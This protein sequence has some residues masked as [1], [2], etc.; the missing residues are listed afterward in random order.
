MGS[1]TL[2]PGSLLLLYLDFHCRRQ[3][4]GDSTTCPPSPVIS[5]P[6]WQLWVEA[7]SMS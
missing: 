1:G 6:S 7:V 4:L 3:C 2:V 5:A